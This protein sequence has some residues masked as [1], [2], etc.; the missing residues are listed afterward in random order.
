MDKVREPSNSEYSSVCSL[1]APFH[2]YIWTGFFYTQLTLPAFARYLL[3]L[4][5]DPED[6][7]SKFLQN[8]GKPV[9]GTRRHISQ[10]IVF[11]TEMKT[12]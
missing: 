8:V 5:F 12:A 7:T 11:I 1:W 3:G 10:D 6:V 2:S 9:S 4:L